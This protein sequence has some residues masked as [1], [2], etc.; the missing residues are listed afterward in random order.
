MDGSPRGDRESR[1]FWRAVRTAWRGPCGAESSRY[2]SYVIGSVS[3]TAPH[4]ARLLP[5]ELVPVAAAGAAA[6]NDE[7]MFWIPPGS[8]IAS[9]T[10]HLPNTTPPNIRCGIAITTTQQHPVIV[11]IL[12]V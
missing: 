2:L 4:V 1:Y 5:A 8:D 12:S 9:P 10:S 7:F 11:S 6:E 3:T